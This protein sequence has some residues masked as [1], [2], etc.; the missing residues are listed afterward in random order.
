MSHNP[1]GFSGFMSGPP[2]PIIRESPT[3]YELIQP[4]HLSY[5]TRT[6]IRHYSD[7]DLQDPCPIDIHLR[8]IR[9]CNI[10]DPNDRPTFRD[11]HSVIQYYRRTDQDDR[12]SINDDYPPPH[13]RHGA[14]SGI[15]RGQSRHE[16]TYAQYGH[17]DVPYY[18]DRR[19]ARDPEDPTYGSG[20][21][22]MADVDY[23]RRAPQGSA[24]SRPSEFGQDR[25]HAPEA[26]FPGIETGDPYVGDLEFDPSQVEFDPIDV[27][28]GYRLRRQSRERRMEERRGRGYGHGRSSQ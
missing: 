22:E 20:R 14:N 3:P 17:R 24:H 2:S 21:H 13:Q 6:K 19:Y 4:R 11:E 26:Y 23:R 27:E 15:S 1:Y 7:A 12:P 5:H 10:D 16:P 28:E 8:P 18:D 9:Y 25:G